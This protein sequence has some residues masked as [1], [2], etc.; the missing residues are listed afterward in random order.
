[1]VKVHSRWVDTVLT[2]YKKIV[3]AEDISINK[4]EVRITCM[5]NNLSFNCCGL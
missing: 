2:S 1:V 3:Q 5:H 4:E